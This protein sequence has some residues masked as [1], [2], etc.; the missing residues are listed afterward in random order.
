MNYKKFIIRSLMHSSRIWTNHCPNSSLPPP[1]PWWRSSHG[2]LRRDNLSGCQHGPCAPS[3]SRS[4]VWWFGIEDK[5]RYRKFLAIAV[6]CAP[7]Q[8]HAL[9]PCS[10]Q[11]IINRG[12]N[13][14]LHSRRS[15]DP[16]D[17]RIRWYGTKI[18]PQAYGIIKAKLP[19]WPLGKLHETW[20]FSPKEGLLKEV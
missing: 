17:H 15:M 20:S 19:S 18:W 4:W 7:Q 2:T 3:S 5:V 12:E 6:A 1:F 11:T 10:T 9:L 14:K 16:T 13:V 8:W